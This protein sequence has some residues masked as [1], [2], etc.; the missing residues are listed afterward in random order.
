MKLITIQLKQLKAW[1]HPINNNFWCVDELWLLLLLYPPPSLISKM[2]KEHWRRELKALSGNYANEKVFSDQLF[3][4]TAS[5]C[6]SVER[7]WD[8]KSL[9]LNIWDNLINNNLSRMSP[10][11]F[12][13]ELYTCQILQWQ[14]IVFW[15]VG[16]S[17]QPL[18]Q[19][20]S[21]VNCHSMFS[22]G[23]GILERHHWQHVPGRSSSEL[24]LFFCGQNLG[25]PCLPNHWTC[26]YL[27]YSCF[28]FIRSYLRLHSTAK[29]TDIMLLSVFHHFTMLFLMSKDCRKYAAQT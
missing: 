15:S 28:A 3:Y 21:F 29:Y 20:Y 13:F 5:N 8:V 17:I 2:N 11:A 27:L 12:V 26:E 7:I 19:V 18:L 22:Y 1:R 14:L 24:P 4:S 9:L 16:M 10:P 6:L 25:L 23:T